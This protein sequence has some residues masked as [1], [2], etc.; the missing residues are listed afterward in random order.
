MSK[1][2]AVFGFSELRGFVPSAPDARRPLSLSLY[3]DR[4]NCRVLQV[5]HNW[6]LYNM[7]RSSIEPIIGS[8]SI[9][10]HH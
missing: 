5:C 2:H 8:G 4:C 1:F 3:S 6:H 7:E 9:L 10:A